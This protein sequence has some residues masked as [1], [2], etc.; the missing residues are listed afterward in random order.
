MAIRFDQIPESLFTLEHDLGAEAWKICDGSGWLHVDGEPDVRC[1]GCDSCG[2]PTTTTKEFLDELT[3]VLKEFKSSGALFLDYNHKAASKKK[4]DEKQF[5]L[6]R[7]AVVFKEKTEAEHPD[8]LKK[9]EAIHGFNFFSRG[10]SVLFGT[11]L[12]PFQGFWVDYAVMMPD[13]I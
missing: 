13:S 5:Y 9:I 3:R 7:V 2:M 1:G 12:P 6:R 11:R 8:L 4:R 10:D